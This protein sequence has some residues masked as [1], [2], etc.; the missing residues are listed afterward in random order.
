MRTRLAK[1]AAIAGALAA[2]T[3]LAQTTHPVDSAPTTATATRMAGA[4]ALEH[5]WSAVLEKLGSPEFKEREEAQKEV[6]KATWHDLPALQAL[7]EKQAD[8]E[9]KERL[10]K[11]VDELH[12]QLAFDPL[13]IDFDVQ[14]GTLADVSDAMTKATGVEWKQWRNGSGQLT[15]TL[16][17]KEQPLWDV[18]LALSAQHPLAVQSNGL[19][20]AQ[21][22]TV[23]GDRRG[24]FFFYP[25]IL[26]RVTNLQERPNAPRRAAPTVP[27]R[28]PPGLPGIPPGAPYLNLS[29]TVLGDPRLKVDSCSAPEITSV[30]DDK[31]NVVYRAQA[32]NN[33]RIFSQGM[34]QFPQSIALPIPENL[35]RTITVKGEMK[36]S[37][38]IS[39][40][41]VEVPDMQKQGKTPIL[42][43]DQELIWDKF[44]PRNGIINI[45][46][47]MR[48]SG[49]QLMGNMKPV[50]ITFI[51]ASGRQL[52]SQSI[53]GGWGGGIGGSDALPIKGIF[54]IPTRVEER[55]IPFE[56]KDLPVP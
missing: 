43:M 25:Q 40:V 23:W 37:I 48:K 24:A 46:M 8:V 2:A 16:H 14:D 47:A 34:I 52:I 9:V 29:Y 36:V 33:G 28:R 39:Q 31:G 17:V 49:S 20:S 21:P 45:Q 38:A 50:R 11:R 44:E 26:S 3:V 19:V 32:T 27:P 54:S 22:G 30:T 5:Q 41:T 6:E 13:P 53:Q 4:D 55:I 15:F 10:M 1:I 7:A 35:G 51:D 56:F 18:F 42:V 12:V